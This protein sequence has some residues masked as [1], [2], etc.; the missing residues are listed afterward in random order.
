MAQISMGIVHA[1][2]DTLAVQHSAYHI[3]QKLLVITETTNENHFIP[4]A[5]NVTFWHSIIASS[6]S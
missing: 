6:N 5:L 3:F 1:S 4:E 2:P